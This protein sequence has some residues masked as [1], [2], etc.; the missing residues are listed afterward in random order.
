MQHHIFC[1]EFTKCDKESFNK[2]AFL[3]K[4]Q[5]K[6][7]WW[8]KHPILP[9]IPRWYLIWM[10][11]QWWA[12]VEHYQKIY[13]QRRR[14]QQKVVKSKQMKLWFASVNISELVNQLIK[15]Q[16]VLIAEHACSHTTSF[17]A[18]ESTSK[19]LVNKFHAILCILSPETL[20]K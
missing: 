3:K 4:Y 12:C 5:T 6:L 15:Y 1:S 8:V 17:H 9:A 7:H 19:T 10:I 13:S 14:F 20:F 2:I 11:W 18:V 16:K